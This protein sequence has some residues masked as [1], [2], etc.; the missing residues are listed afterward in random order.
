MRYGIHTQVMV[1]ISW[2]VQENQNFQNADTV[3][4]SQRITCA[5]TDFV[6]SFYSIIYLITKDVFLPHPN[7]HTQQKY[8]A[9][10]LLQSCQV[11][12]LTFQKN[13]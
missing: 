9:K 11:F 6:K 12:L 2:S 4:V 8:L 5:F 10:T 1:P 7:W 3:R 13:W